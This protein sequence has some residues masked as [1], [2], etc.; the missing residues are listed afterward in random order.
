MDMDLAEAIFR[1]HEFLESIHREFVLGKILDMSGSY[2]FFVL[3][4][5]KKVRILTIGTKT[6]SFGGP[7]HPAQAVLLRCVQRMGA[8]VEL[9]RSVVLAEFPDFQIF[10]AFAV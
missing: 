8:F 3:T 9:S 6:K 1:A 10:Y 7:T 5:L 2:S 4:N